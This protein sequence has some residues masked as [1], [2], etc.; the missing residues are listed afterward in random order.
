ME[1]HDLSSDVPVLKLQMKAG[2]DKT[3][4]KYAAE[5]QGGDQAQGERQT[6]MYGFIFTLHL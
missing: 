1:R 5:D 3:A 6:E 2:K 4:G